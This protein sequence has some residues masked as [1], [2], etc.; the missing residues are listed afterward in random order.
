V[1]EASS[2]KQE[3]VVGLGRRHCFRHEAWSE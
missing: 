1:P 2:D 3:F